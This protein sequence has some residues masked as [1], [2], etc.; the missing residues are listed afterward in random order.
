LTCLLAEKRGD[1]APKGHPKTFEIRTV[2]RT[3]RDSNRRSFSLLRILR[4]Y[5]ELASGLL[6]AFPEMLQTTI[7]RRRSREK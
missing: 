7:S 3:V 5:M 6:L 2:D 1:G 4:I